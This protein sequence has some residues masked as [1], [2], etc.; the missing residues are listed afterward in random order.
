VTVSPGQGCHS[1]IRAGAAWSRCTIGI[2]STSA[3]HV[4]PTATRQTSAHASVRGARSAITGSSA[5]EDSHAT[6]AVLGD[7]LTSAEPSFTRTSAVVTDSP[8]RSGIS[9]TIAEPPGPRRATRVRACHLSPSS[10][11]RSTRTKGGRDFDSKARA[12]RS[13]V[14]S[15]TSCRVPSARP[16][17][18][19]PTRRQ[20]SVRAVTWCGRSGKGISKV[21]RSGRGPSR[22]T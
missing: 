4:A 21:S 17:P 16:P 5:R 20:P 22:M 10:S 14:R 19:K 3:C 7:R 8:G 9:R 2:P 11:S 18:C 1:R 15:R 13:V 12:A 6:S